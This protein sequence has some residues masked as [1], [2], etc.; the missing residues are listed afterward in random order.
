[1]LCL[2]RAVEFWT[3]ML[4]PALRGTEA[5]S[6][7]FAWAEALVRMANV[8]MPAGALDGASDAAVEGMRKFIMSCDASSTVCNA[9]S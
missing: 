2:E 1:M 9:S 5:Q 8:S 4:S 7:K 6:V 3:E